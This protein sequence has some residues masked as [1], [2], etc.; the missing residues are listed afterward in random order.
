MM[1][2]AP[3]WLIN[4]MPPGYQTRAAEIQRLSAELD[5][6]D[7]IG[8]LLWQTGQPLKDAVRDMFIALRYETEVQSDAAS[9]DVGVALDATRRL[10]VRVSKTDG[11][12]GKKS[13]DLV[14]VFQTLSEVAGDHDRVVLAAN[15]HRETRPLDRPASDDIAP[16]AL[17]LLQRI[18][19]NILTPATLF[20]IWSLSLKEDVNRARAHIER[21]HTQNGGEFQL[22]SP[23]NP[24]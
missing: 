18:G 3:D 14:A 11:V 17:D 20:R 10:F 24:S 15:N 7:R 23:P 1:E 6:M 12:I 13:P 9:Y 2:K 19:A 16:D 21:L 8:W 22:P 5:A 4:E